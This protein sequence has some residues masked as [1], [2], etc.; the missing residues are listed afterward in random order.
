MWCFSYH[1]KAIQWWFKPRYVTV[2]LSLVSLLWFFFATCL[3]T[4]SRW[5]SMQRNS[6]AK[7]LKRRKKVMTSAHSHMAAGDLK[8]EL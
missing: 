5:H 6:A 8:P 4:V 7:R 2:F 1:S 3:Y